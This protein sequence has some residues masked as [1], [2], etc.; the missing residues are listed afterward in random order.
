MSL[1]DGFNRLHLANSKHT[2]R[3][4]IQQA[5]KNK[6]SYQELLEVLVGEEVAHRQG[7]RLARLS[8]KA[9]FPFLKTID[10]YDFSH[11]KALELRLFASFLSPDFVADG[12]SLVLQGG[13]GRGKTHLAIAVAYRAIQNG[14][15]ARFV[16]AASLIDT[17]SRASREGR[18]D[19]VVAQ[20]VA[21]HVLVVDE[22]GYLSYGT[23]AANVL[24]HVVNDRHLKKRA[25]VFT[26]NKPLQAW[27]QVLHDDDLAEAIVD[28][29]LE[30]GRLIVLGGPSMRKRHLGP[31]VLASLGEVHEPARISGKKRPEFPEPTL[32]KDQTP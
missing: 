10:E 6:W 3:G 13:P 31:E 32:R 2:W 28:R 27:G 21:P 8:R 30:R 26:T 16:T 14:Y 9:R 11:Q 18:F 22:V 4:L 23:D 1:D 15:E 24:F 12:R 17:L 25:M 5:E 7:T 20:F 19:E 29:I